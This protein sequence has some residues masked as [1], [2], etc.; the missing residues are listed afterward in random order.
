MR[1]LIGTECGANFSHDNIHIIGADH[2]VPGFEAVA[3][4]EKVDTVKVEPGIVALAQTAVLEYP[5]VKAF[6]VE[7]TEIPHYSNAIRRATGLPVFDVTTACNFFINSFRNEVRFGMQNWQQ[8]W[9]GKQNEY[10]FGQNLAN[11][12]K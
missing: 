1:H 7:C 10:T 8:S 12:Q 11:K 4:G 2:G 9:D 3:L 5:K 6:L